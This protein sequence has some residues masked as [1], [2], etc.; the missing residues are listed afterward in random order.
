[1][2]FQPRFAKSYGT[3]ASNQTKGSLYKKRVVDKVA[4]FSYRQGLF[5]FPLF[6]MQNI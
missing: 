6:C 4:A 5:F 3:S 2:N 1:M